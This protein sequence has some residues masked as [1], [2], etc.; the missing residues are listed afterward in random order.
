[1][2][3][4][5]TYPRK[6]LIDGLKLIVP[7][8]I[9]VAIGFGFLRRAN[10]ML[11]PAALDFA[12]AAAIGITAGLLTRQS[13]KGRSG[14]LH[15]LVAVAATISALIILGLVTWGQAGIKMLIL[16]P[17]TDWNAMGQLLVGASSALLALRAW[18][19]TV[20]A[21]PLPPAPP[22]RFVP[23]PR[24]QPVPTPS[25]QSRPR[26]APPAPRVSARAQ[27]SS[28]LPRW[29]P[30]HIALPQF[31][32]RNPFRQIA[33]PHFN[34]RNPFQSRDS[35]IKVTGVTEQRCPYCLDLIMSNDPRGVHLC[36]ICHTP[37][38]GDCWALTGVCQVPHYHA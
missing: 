19:A 2:S 35:A 26:I 22:E 9:L 23:R 6:R 11:L 28:R 13:L 33:L 38:H 1:M 32:F 18:R 29:T 34:V 7:S 12:T 16:R 15:A 8:T 10:Q 20:E 30:P 5:G 37:H 24:T 17:D 25:R 36:P 21:L 31:N 4:L 14:L 3:E 27:A